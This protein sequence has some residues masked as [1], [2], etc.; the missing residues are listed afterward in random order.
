MSIYN[1]VEKIVKQ[2]IFVL[3]AVLA[4]S[5]QAEP[6][7]IAVEGSASI[8]A[9]PDIIRIR[10]SVWSVGTGDIVA[11]KQMVDSTASKSVEELVA[12]G[13]D[14]EKITSPGLN[15]E[16]IEQYGPNGEYIDSKKTQIATGYPD[17]A[18]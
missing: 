5:A 1:R 13:I 17:L 12:L 9:V 2:V 14:E 7:I 6:R 4:F 3:L 15:V 10:Y 16:K 11:M 8:E 18:L